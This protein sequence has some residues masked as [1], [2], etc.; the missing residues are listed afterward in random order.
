[1]RARSEPGDCGSGEVGSPVLVEDTVHDRFEEA[2]GLGI[3][4]WV[5]RVL[6]VVLAEIDRG[7][8]V[9]VV[10]PAVTFVGV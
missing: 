2:Q 7:L 3:V 10:A 1:M 5:E 4:V 9:R 6:V 8:V